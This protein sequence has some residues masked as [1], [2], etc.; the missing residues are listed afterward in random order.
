MSGSWSRVRLTVLLAV[1]FLAFGCERSPAEFGD[2]AGSPADHRSRIMDLGGRETE[3]VEWGQEGPAVVLIHGASMTPH[4]FD[5]FAARFADRYYLVAFARRGHGKATPP[6]GQFDVDDLAEDL[7]IFMDSL[8]IPRA[9]L[10]GHSFGGHE[11]T[12]F[13]AHHPERVDGLVYLDADFGESGDAPVMLALGSLPL[14]PCVQGS[15]ESMSSYRHCISDYIMAPHE[16]SSSLEEMIVDGLTDTIGPV[17]YR[18]EAEHVVSSLEAV[19]SG[20][21]REYEALKPPALFLMSDTYFS[22]QTVDST[23]NQRFRAWHDSSG[24]AEARDANVQRVRRLLPNA[25]VT[26]VDGTSHDNFMLFE[27]VAEQVDRFLSRIHP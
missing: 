17:V 25:R 14:P 8:G 10:M 1:G 5:Q 2:R 3:V 18:V 15:R 11:I 26:V 9:T 4:M 13:A 23:W 16:W 6:S 22:V 24:Y 21:R 27:Q 7:R 19:N 12:R 20:Y